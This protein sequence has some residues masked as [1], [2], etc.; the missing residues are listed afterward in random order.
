MTN[1]M[2]LIAGK[3]SARVRTMHDSAGKIVLKALPGTAVTVSG[4]KDLPDAGD[5]VLSGTE[6]EVKKALHNRLR[7]AE[8]S[9]MLKDVEVINSQRAQERSSAESERESNDTL[10]QSASGPKELRVIVKADVSGS[11]EALMGAI[12]GLGNHQAQVKV[13]H[14]GVGDVNDSDLMLAKV[15]QGTQPTLLC[16]TFPFSIFLSATIIAFSV[17]A[18][19]AV[20]NAAMRDAIPI[21]KSDIIYRVMEEVKE[22]LIPLLPVVV[23]TKI[24]GSAIVQ[25][26]FEITLKGRKVIQVAGCKVFSG[27][28]EKSRIAKVLRDDKILYE[29]Q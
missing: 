14:T 26:I 20:E 24:H 28:A 18:S 17:K 1:S 15:S 11:A 6:E 3:T 4:W 21:Y 19:R 29:G 12:D 10:V 2:H 8:I 23:T 7:Q 25:A 13:I 5:E 22:R 16:L 27:I 9:S